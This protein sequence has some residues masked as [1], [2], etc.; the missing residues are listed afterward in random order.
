MTETPHYCTVTP[1]PDGYRRGC[2]DWPLC[3]FSPPVAGDGITATTP[4]RAVALDVPATAPHDSAE[5]GTTLGED[6]AALAGWAAGAVLVLVV[7]AIV[8]PVIL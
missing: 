3:V 7:L 8:L 5:A 2:P 6:L 1:G 4:R